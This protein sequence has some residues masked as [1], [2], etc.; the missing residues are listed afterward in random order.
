MLRYL[1]TNYYNIVRYV[2][3]AAT[4]RITSFYG[5]NTYV[6]SIDNEP[7]WNF[8]ISIK[9]LQLFQFQGE[10]E[11]IVEDNDKVIDQILVLLNQRRERQKQQKRIRFWIR[12]WISRRFLNGYFHQ[13]MQEW[14]WKWGWTFIHKLPQSGTNMFQ[15]L[16]GTLNARIQKHDTSFWKAFEPELKLGITLW[17]LERGE[18]YKSFV[19][20]FR[21]SHNTISI[22]VC[23]VCESIIA[24]YADQAIPCP[25]IAHEWQQ[26]A[27]QFS[28]RHNLHVL[29]ALDG[30]HI[31]IQCH[32]KW[33]LLYYNYKGAHS[34][35]LIRVVGDD[36]EFCIRCY[37]I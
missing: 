24:K 16:V 30:K 28:V 34:L 26:I 8:S 21:V 25:K 2:Q 13:I 6:V 27:E 31:A 10:L 22:M 11:H 23:D 3:N 9:V 7:V 37:G 20:G 4:N 1:C 19:Y 33:C 12:P 5:K 14:T 17:Y 18:S 29:G 35:I 32:W 36:Y 15:E